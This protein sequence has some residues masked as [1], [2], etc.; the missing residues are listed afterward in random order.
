M[1]GNNAR[2]PTDTWPLFVKQFFN[3]KLVTDVLKIGVVVGAKEWRQR[4]DFWI[5]VGKN[6]EIG[7]AISLLMGSGEG[8]TE[9][10]ER[11]VL[12]YTAKRAIQVGGSYHTNMLEVIRELKPVKLE[13]IA[14][15]ISDL[16]T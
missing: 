3:E 2:L 8:S 9:M 10:R 5:E 15:V 7:K 12:S 14:T 4:I 1:E 13:R 16:L 6:E 11:V